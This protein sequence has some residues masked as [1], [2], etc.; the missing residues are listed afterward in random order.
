MGWAAQGGGWGHLEAFKDRLDVALGDK[1]SPRLDLDDL[2]R[3]FP[4]SAVLEFCAP[5][6]A[7]VAN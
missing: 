5:V 4:T 7:R 2:K 3:S 1:A 6:K